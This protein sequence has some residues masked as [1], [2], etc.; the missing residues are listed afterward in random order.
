VNAPAGPRGSAGAD[1]EIKGLRVSFAERGGKARTVL[2]VPVFRVAGGSHVALC[3]PSGSGK[4]TFL[5][6]LAGLLRP[7]LGTVRWAGL[8][9]TSM[10]ER[11]LDRWR[12]ESVGLVFQQFH[13]FAGLSAL[14]NVL[15]PLQFTRWSIPREQSRRAL[16]LLA[17][18]GVPP[19]AH[20][21]ALSRGEQQR[22]AVARAL[23]R[24]PAIVLADEPTASLDHDTGRRIADTLRTLCREAHATLIVAT[25][26]GALAGEFG[27]AYEIAGRSVHPRIGGR[28]EKVATAT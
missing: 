18:V 24:S 6:L 5:H 20:V 26:D 28:V 10:P 23:L 4:T 2:D 19:R 13:L 7:Q 11:A 25:H 17:H 22:V 1:L 3:G 15:L 16:D 27:R 12:R 21:E 8:E 14:D 9:L